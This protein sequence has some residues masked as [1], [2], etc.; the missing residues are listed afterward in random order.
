MLTRIE[1]DNWDELIPYE[2]VTLVRNGSPGT[3]LQ[4][5]FHHAIAARGGGWQAMFDVGGQISTRY[6]SSDWTVIRVRIGSRPPAA[7]K[8]PAHE[9]T[10]HWHNG[11]SSHR[12]PIFVP[13]Q[14]SPADAQADRPVT[15]ADP[16]DQIGERRRSVR[17]IL[18]RKGR[19]R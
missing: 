17:A 8:P 19:A 9:E 16:K 2:Q 3:Q 5:C 10:G 12:N 15:T 18:T 14:M 6:T 7:P 13:R 1:V 4:A 11:S